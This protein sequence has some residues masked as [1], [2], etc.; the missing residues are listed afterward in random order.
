MTL[1]ITS[2]KIFKYYDGW[3]QYM[4][5][6]WKRGMDNVRFVEGSAQD[7]EISG[8]SVEPREEFIFNVVRKLLEVAKAQGKEIDLSLQLSQRG[9]YDVEEEKVFQCLLSTIMLSGKNAK[10]L[11]DGLDKVY[12][13]GQAVFHVKNVRE[14]EKTLNQVLEIEN[15]EDPREAFFDYKS[16]SR[17][18][19]DGNFCGRKYKISR[20]ALKDIY[21]NKLDAMV[22]KEDNEVID[23]WYKRRKRVNYLPLVSGEYKRE[24]LIDRAR[25]S[26]LSQPAKKGWITYI[27]YCRVLEDFDDFLEKY[28]LPTV[29]CLPL[30]FNYGGIAWI[31]GKYQ[32]FPFGYHLRDAQ[33]LM[34]FSGRLIADIMKSTNAD[35][36]LFE[37]D[38]LKNQEAR[39]CAEEINVREGALTFTG[40]IQKIRREPSQQ[41]PQGVLEFFSQL[42]QVIQSLA[43]SYFEGNSALIKATSGVAL[44]KMH[45]RAD[46]QQN[47]II[48]AHLNTVQVV[49]NIIKTL[50]PVYYKE[51]RELIV[52]NVDGN[53][54]TLEI[55]QL[56]TQPNGLTI[57]KNNVN[58]ICVNYDYTMKVAPSMKMQRQNMKAEL[59][60]IY[61][62]YPQ[63]V[64]QTIDIYADSL[65]ISASKML[66]RR[67]G[68]NIPPELIEYGDGDMTYEQ[69]QQVTQEKQ[70][71]MMQEQQIME[72]QNPNYQYMQARTQTEHVKGQTA[73]M[74]AQTAQLKETSA[75]HNA[76]IKNTSNAVKVQMEN[77]NAVAQ[78]DLEILKTYMQHINDIIESLGREYR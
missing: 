60:S 5:P 73:L 45:E 12:S 52:Q 28:T 29:N 56:I 68:V 15:I 50:I 75:A 62:I 41:L 6:S 40:D 61:Q 39:L 38:H 77:K 21:K 31:D 33:I 9:D 78:H 58:N 11:A 36:W 16:P 24:D 70:R 23:F 20:K 63:A 71:Q 2:K 51:N 4:Q 55:N 67:L 42:P 66:S 48:C 43:G 25:D 34:N 69:Y 1:K 22:L 65:D 47:P 17:T 27:E 53:I 57:V 37:A 18:F 19:H 3:K 64:N 8:G 76:L 7:N 54:T 46:L 35:R 32:T 30:V 44:D 10:A 59:L 74:D 72:Q 26:L 13:F 49:A 14:D